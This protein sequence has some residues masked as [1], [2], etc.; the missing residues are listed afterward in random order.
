[1]YHKQ[2]ALLAITPRT[3]RNAGRQVSVRAVTELLE[4]VYYGNRYTGPK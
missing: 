2:K 4:I 1:M 3:L